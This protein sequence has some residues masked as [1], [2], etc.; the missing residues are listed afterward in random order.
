MS[1]ATDF[2][3]RPRAPRAGEEIDAAKLAAWLGPRVEGLE[4]PLAIEQFPSGHS[5]LTYRVRSAAG[6]REVVLR[7]PPFGTTVKTAHD[8][9]REHRILSRLDAVFPLAPRALAL[10]DDASVIGAPFYVMERVCGVILRGTRPPRGLEIAPAVMRGVSEALADGLAALHAVDWRA[11]GLADL[12]H[13]D[14]YVL[15]QVRGWTERYRAARTDDLPDVERAA[16]WLA[17]NAPPESGAA[18]IH[19]DW[20]YDNLVL[21]PQSLSSSGGPAARCSGESATRPAPPSSPQIR[22][23]LD[24][25][26][27]TI[28]DPLMDLGTTLGYWIDPDDAEELCALPLGP[29]L[30]PGNLTRRELVERYAART[31]RAVGRAEALF[32]YVYGLVKVIGIAQ[33]IYFRFKKGLTRDERFATFGVAVLILGR[34]AARAIERGRVAAGGA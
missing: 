8:M 21:D 9:G 6:D 31:G 3:D 18:L 1:G 17:A 28:G 5:N 26:M 4:G 30:L 7:R 19:G 16:A 23:V 12:G 2:T 10:C 22:A 14:G 13:P 20:K 25:E 34:A 11:A 29:T 33:Q 24:W 15:R 32:Y 27:A